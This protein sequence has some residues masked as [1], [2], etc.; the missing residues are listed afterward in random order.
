MVSN[1]VHGQIGFPYCEDF[2][3][4]TLQESTV[5]GGR[6]RIVDGVLR[7]TDA[8]QFQS[9]FMY[10]DIPFPSAF[11][12]KTSFEFF[13]YGGDGADGFSVFLFDGDAPF[14]SPGGFGGSLGYAP[15]NDEPGLSRAYLG[16]G[17]DAFGNFASVAE[18][19]VGG[20]SSNPDDR[21]PNSVYLRGA[22]NQFL[23]YQGIG[24]VVTQMSPQVPNGSPLL[25]NAV[26]RFNLSSGGSG[27]QRVTDPN[28][29]GYRK[30]F[31]DLSPRPNGVGYL[32]NVEFLVTTTPN[33]PR[34]VPVLV[35]QAYDFAAPR[36]LKIGFAAS[37]GGSTNIHEIRDLQVEVS[38]QEGLEN[39]S[40][41]DIDDKASC[42]GQEN[43]YVIGEE[44]VLLPN[45]DSSIR[46]IQFYASLD[47]IR[48]EEEDVC[49]QGRCRPEN[50]VLII[51]QGTFTADEFGGG[52]TF[53]PNPGFIDETVEI[54]YTITDSYGKSSSGN[55]IRLLIQ[56]SP[57]PVQIVHAETGLPINQQRI[58]E[59][60]IVPLLAQG[61][62]TYVRFE[63]Y[64]NDNLI[65]DA[66]EAVFQ[67][68]EAGFYK[69]IAFNDKSCPT[70]S[71]TIE[72][73]IPDFPFLEVTS[74]AIT[75]EIGGEVDVREY[76]TGYDEALFDYRVLS[77]GG[78]ILINEELGGIAIAGI[79]E[80]QVKHKDL[81]CWSPSV[82]LE[83]SINLEEMV[84][85]F[86]FE[87]EG[88]GVSIEDAGGI[89]IDD[90]IRFIASSAGNVD[91][92]LW[93]FGD[94]NVSE[95][96]SP[97]HVFGQRGEFVVTLT[98]ENELGCQEFFSNVVAVTQSFRVMIPTGFTPSLAQ[99]NFFVPKTKGIVSI[100]LSVFNLW[101]NLVYQSSGV[102]IPGWD[103]RINDQDA[104]SGTYV[105]S[106]QLR[107]VD[108]EI[109]DKT[110]KFKLIR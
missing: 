36:N 32:L 10:I 15:R 28:Q 88:T 17:I 54:F 42:E 35:D 108:G 23:G 25:L 20:F 22:G 66:D 100:E 6:A 77:F 105:Y 94:G 30:V 50:R 56:E 102:D 60:D 92:W 80:V 68:R 7:L 69:V 96:P 64:F 63:W 70:E 46:C 59:G 98:A 61:E 37:T 3:G 83:V 58:C 49:S 72:I 106:V 31:I 89:F 82:S 26:N 34:L 43:T 16:I 4:G 107:S 12:I 52:F 24:G 39:P 101:G 97:V 62:E 104:P 40:A 2:G 8:Q 14:F 84:P 45:D 44:E 38:D 87:I 73:F 71:E 81:E 29:V 11:G 99:N 67:A 1:D 21:F 5:L 78:D 47:E 91:R 27:T 18:G 41:I 103:G 90:P 57:E 93:D 79:Y 48:A 55:S 110:G 85:A 9:G 13:M 95:G 86:T 65:L 74:P 76:I 53:F 75:C 33:Q 109:I 51:P 19:K